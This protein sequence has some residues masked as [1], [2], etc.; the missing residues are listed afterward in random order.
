MEHRKEKRIPEKN[1]VYIKSAEEI[2]G[3]NHGVGLTAYTYDISLGGAR[4]F[5]GKYFAVGTV[6]RIVLE[7]RR[8][9][10]VVQVDGE[11]KWSRHREED[12]VFEMGVEFLT[13]LRHLY[14]MENGISTSVSAF[15][16]EPAAAPAEAA[17]GG[18]EAAASNGGNGSRAVTASGPEN[19]SGRKSR[20]KRKKT[21]PRASSSTDPG[22][23]AKTTP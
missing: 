10:Q 17:R 12:G 3:D 6:L 19:G 21:K 1:P 22:R 8:T 7:L 2:R 23:Q 5:C 18:S 11:V 16:A 15:S 4:L 14:G 13:L 20:G 9:S